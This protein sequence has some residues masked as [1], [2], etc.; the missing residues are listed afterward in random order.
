MIFKSERKKQ[1]RLDFIKNSFLKNL[2]INDCHA[3]SVLHDKKQKRLLAKTKFLAQFL[4]IKNLISRETRK[5]IINKC[6]NCVLYCEELD[7]KVWVYLLNI[8]R[9]CG[10]HDNK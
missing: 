9:K 10:K 6:N 7:E 2:K 3:L 1:K 4:E 8:Y 5:R